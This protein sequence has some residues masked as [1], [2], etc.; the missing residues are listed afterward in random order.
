[1]TGEGWE[2][3]NLFAPSQSIDTHTCK[4]RWGGDIPAR[5]L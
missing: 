3:G 2:V 5:V 1:V 4:F